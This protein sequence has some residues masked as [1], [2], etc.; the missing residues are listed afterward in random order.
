MEKILI[1][2]IPV[3][4][5]G[6]RKFLESHK[7]VG[8]LYLWGES[9]F[10]EADYLS[11]EIR[12]LDPNLM[13]KS[14]NA[15]NYGFD[16]KILTKA[17][18]EEIINFTGE[19]IMPSDDISHTFKEKFLGDKKVI[20]DNVFLRWE[21]RNSV[22]ENKIANDQ[23][24]TTDE[25]SRKIIAMAETEAE[26]SSDWWR[27]V[28]A[29]I[30][31]D[32]KVI[33]FGHNQHLPSEHT[34]YVN[35]DPRNC[36]HKGEHLDLSTAIHIEARLIAEA[37][38]EGVSLSGAEIYVTTFPCP[39]CAKMIAYSGIKK[40]YYKEGYGVLDGESVLKGKGVEIYFVQ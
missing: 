10:E 11:K 20:F 37:A 32:G 36:F 6:Y 9:L 40:I 28:G 17:N 38:K 26:K 14:L 35:G 13:K 7:E 29:V 16:I 23:V 39:P 25:F 34:P 30:I 8:V 15:L 18:L 12:A 24:V 3:L 2:Y 5:E 4:H 1:A 19:I 22:R 31:K 33:S 21:K 27:H